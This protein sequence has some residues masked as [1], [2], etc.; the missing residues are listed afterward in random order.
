MACLESN[1]SEAPLPGAQSVAR[2][3][4]T[5]SRR[6]SQ[7]HGH[8]VWKAGKGSSE[9]GHGGPSLSGM[10]C[11][12]VKTVL[13]PGHRQPSTWPPSALESADVPP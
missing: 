4:G 13:L 8:G 6:H 7:H 12:G 3:H 11:R 1:D 10:V 2:R 5:E 9:R